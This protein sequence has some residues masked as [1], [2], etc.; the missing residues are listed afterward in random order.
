[1]R[2]VE[3]IKRPLK[4]LLTTTVSRHVALHWTI[5]LL[6]SA[7]C[8]GACSS[9]PQQTDAHSDL[10]ILTPNLHTYQWRRSM[11]TVAC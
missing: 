1:M 3:L 9:K 11:S 8:V 7:H 6:I 10:A 2:S 4:Q 5:L